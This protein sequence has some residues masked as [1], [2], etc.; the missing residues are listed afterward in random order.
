VISWIPHGEATVLTASDGMVNTTV[1]ITFTSMGLDCKNLPAVSYLNLCLLDLPAFSIPDLHNEDI[2]ANDGRV[3]TVP[4]SDMYWETLGPIPFTPTFFDEGCNPSY[5]FG[6]YGNMVF[7]C[8]DYSA[9]LDV[10]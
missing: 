7:D 3:L 9:E 4:P 2:E 10:F 8:E 6:S 1:T 5:M